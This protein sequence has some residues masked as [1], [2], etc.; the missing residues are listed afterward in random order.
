V[1]DILQVLEGAT[2]LAFILGAI[3]AVYELRS[4]KRDRR[5]EF[6]MRLMDLGINREFQDPMSKIW[7]TNASNAEELEKEVSP[8]D[9]YTIGEFWSWAAFLAEAGWVERKD[10]LAYMDYQSLWKKMGP[11][12]VAERKATGPMWGSIEEFAEMQAAMATR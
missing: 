2:Y 6:L 5:F 8:A 7:R 1:V 9:L 12:I 10:L 11:W 4:I 3:V